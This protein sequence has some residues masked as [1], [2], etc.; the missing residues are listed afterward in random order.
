M[1]FGGV[2]H[3]NEKVTEIIPGQIV[4][5]KT[6]KGRY[7]SKTVVLTPGNNWMGENELHSDPNVARLT[8]LFCTN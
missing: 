7:K 1:K 4:E 5:V 2:L 3:D 6:N 8:Y